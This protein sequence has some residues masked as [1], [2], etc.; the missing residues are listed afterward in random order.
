M[1]IEAEIMSEDSFSISHNNLMA[2]IDAKV[3]GNKKLIKA[4]IQAGFWGEIKAIARREAI[5]LLKETWKLTEQAKDQAYVEELTAQIVKSLTQYL[6]EQEEEKSLALV[7]Q[8]AELPA[9]EK[10]LRSVAPIPS[11]AVMFSSMEAYIRKDLWKKDENG[12]AYLR[13]LAKSKPKNYIEHYITSPG[14][15]TLLPWDEAQQIIDKFGF[16][17]AKLHLIF[18]AHATN[19]DKPWESQFHLKASDIIQ[20]FGWDKNHRKSRSE[21]F[22]EIASTAFA[23]DC[24]LVKAVWIEGRNQKGQIIASAP[25]GRLWNV[26]IKP[27]G[28][29]NLEGKID[30]PDEIYITVQP[31]L[32]TR[33]F[34]NRAGARSREALYQ[35][36]YL[37]QQVLKINPYHDELALRLAIFLS[38]DSRIRLEGNYQVQELLEIA[39]PKPVI[40][41]A[42]SDRRKAYDLKQRWDSAIVLLIQLGWQIEFDSKTYPEWLRPESEQQKPKGY[43]DKLLDAH[44]TIKPPNPIPELLAAKVKPKVNPSQPKAK[45][46]Q[47]R[48]TKLT[49]SQVREARKAKS[50]SQ[51]TLA[52]FLGVSQKLISLIERG[53]RPINP[54]LARQICK[55]LLDPS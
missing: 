30:D 27:T 19:Q 51:A 18:A 3:F 16:T 12:I 28:Q 42:R 15:I 41:Q 39:L 34:L 2:E 23:L 37:A 4:Q 24:L 26:Y 49:G 20:E 35:F 25:V 54:K 14:D 5:K 9:S 53:E 31:G 47:N 6:E 29:S 52:G 7:E 38:L 11:S 13:H 40:A 36:G 22:I 44:L 50:W 21:K 10:S 32:W 1:E 8:E 43:L 48:S 33:D 45:R 55:L 17:T 46:K